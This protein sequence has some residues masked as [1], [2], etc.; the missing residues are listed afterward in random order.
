VSELEE[1]DTKNIVHFKEI[2]MR[3]VSNRFTSATGTTNDQL[4]TVN[5][6]EDVNYVTAAFLDPR[7][8]TSIFGSDV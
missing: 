2:L 7:I 1:K 6:F 8:K 4:F 3:N 5:V